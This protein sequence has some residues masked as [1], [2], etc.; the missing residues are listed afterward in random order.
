MGQV[1]RPVQPWLMYL[2]F[3]LGYV[4][5]FWQCGTGRDE[6]FFYSSLLHGWILDLGSWDIGILDIAF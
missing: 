3:C 6:I 2:Y 4:R 5:S 1:G